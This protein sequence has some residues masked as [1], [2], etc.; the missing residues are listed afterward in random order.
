LTTDW[1]VSRIFALGL[2]EALFPTPSGRSAAEEPR[3]C[4]AR[5]CLV[6]VRVGQIVRQPVRVGQQIGEGVVRGAVERPGRCRLSCPGRW[7]G[8]RVVEAFGRIGGPEAAA[9]IERIYARDPE[10]LQAEFSR[11]CYPLYSATPD[12][13]GES[14]RFLA[15]MIR[16]PDVASY[17]S[18]HEAASFDPWSLIGAVRCP[19]LVLAGEDDPVCPLPVVE[20]LAS[21]LPAGTTRLVRLPGAR[22]TIFRDRPDLAFPAVKSF[23]AQTRER[24]P[25]S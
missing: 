1:S 8:P 10:D 21:Q 23:V 3:P 18:S 25:E 13:A 7:G 15:R 20:E 4:L 11:V 6:Q 16:N 19:A 12:W 5:D 24:H 2:G 22:H 14:R 9:I 17:Y